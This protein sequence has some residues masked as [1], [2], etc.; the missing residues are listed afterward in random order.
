MARG[1][2]VVISGAAAAAVRT[3]IIKLMIMM[4]GMIINVHILMGNY[5]QC[6]FN[7]IEL[8]AEIMNFF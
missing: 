7:Y 5:A 1:D 4:R 2:R 6:I 8:E 3:V